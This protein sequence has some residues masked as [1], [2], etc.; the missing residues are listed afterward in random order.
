MRLK[1][2]RLMN[3]CYFLELGDKIILISYESIIGV[4]IGDVMYIDE[5]YIK[6]SKTT[7]KHINLFRRELYNNICV[8]VNSE[9]FNKLVK[10]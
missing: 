2:N 5:R 1:F 3:N 4:I 7:T 6:F 10:N 9:Y 8:S